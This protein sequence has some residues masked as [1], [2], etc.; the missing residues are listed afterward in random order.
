MRKNCNDIIQIGIDIDETIANLFTPWLVWYNTRWKD[1][2]KIKDIPWRID[3]VVKP[4]CGKKIFDYLKL[5]NLYQYQCIQPLPGAVSAVKYLYKMKNVEVSFITSASANIM[6]IDSKIKWLFEYLPFAEPKDLIIANRKELIRF[7][8]FIDDAPHNILNYR[9]AW[10]SSKILTIA[11]PY[12]KDVEQ[13]VNL[14]AKGYKNTVAAWKQI[15]EY[16]E[17][18]LNV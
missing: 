17:E 2:L 13:H 12:N 8:Y 18:D 3:Q 16:I 4:E 7:D 15:V 1:N 9:K 14:R 6:G 11:Y 10:S 5:P